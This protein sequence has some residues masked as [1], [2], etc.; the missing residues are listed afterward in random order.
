MTR[1]SYRAADWAENRD[2]RIGLTKNDR[3]KRFS[4]TYFSSSVIRSLLE[5]AGR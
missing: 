4:G 1:F 5:T 2:S 3:E